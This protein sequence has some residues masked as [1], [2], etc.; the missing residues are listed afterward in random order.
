MDLAG[1]IFFLIFLQFKIKIWNGMEDGGGIGWGDH[2]LPHKFIERTFWH[3]V[4]STKPLLN[5]GGEHQTPRKADHCLQT[6]VGKNI[7][8]KKRRQRR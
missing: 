4:N 5:A 2:F 3:W 1:F 7:K 6:Q 8:D